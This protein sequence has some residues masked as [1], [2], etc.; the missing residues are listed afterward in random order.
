MEHSV[1]SPPWTWDGPTITFV[2]P[3]YGKEIAGG[4][5]YQCR[6]NAEEL[7]ARGIA[8]EVFTTTGGG[9]M[10]DWT[11]PAYDTG[12]STV[13][14]VPVHRFAVRKRNAAI[15]DRV[16]LRLLAGERLSLLD[17][18]VFVREIVG[19]DDL[20]DAVERERKDRLFIFMP[21]MFGTTYW[22]SRRAIDGYMIPCLHDEGYTR[23]HLYRQSIE[24]VR[25]LIFNAPAEQRLAQRLYALDRTPQLLL[26]EGVD[27]GSTPDAQR[28]RDRYVVE[29]P[30]VL[31]AGRRD[32][33]KNTPLLLEA[34]RHYNE[35]GGTLPLVCIGGPGEPLPADLVASGAARDLGR[36]PVEDIYD[37]YAAATVLCQPSVNE[38]FSL[39][40]MEAWGSG[41]PALVHSD[42]AVTSEFCQ[43]TG[44]GLHFRTANEFAAC[45]D[46][47]AEHPDLAR[48]M[49]AAG[50]A[51]VARHFT[52]DTILS[53]LLAFLGTSG[54]YAQRTASR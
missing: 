43:I 37:A 39:V 47:Y 24:N 44:G 14:G 12:T 42:C 19:S 3:W 16:H 1:L 36:L 8:A 53:R 20:E 26:G 9:L 30:F 28:F 41:T 29:G 46:W 54:G 35:Q 52:W 25:G 2:I 4:A 23:M 18:A 22:G 38:S 50:R 11:S 32:I 27:V 15:F 5:E 45:L 40:M 51:Y 49:G 48:E 6:R 10:T 34:F 13:N 21:Y 7:R 17:E 33:T 31:Y